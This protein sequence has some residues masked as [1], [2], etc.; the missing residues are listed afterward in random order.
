MIYLCMIYLVYVDDISVHD[1]SDMFN[2]WKCVVCSE[3]R[4]THAHGMMLP[5]C[6]VFPLALPEEGSFFFR[7]ATLASREERFN[8]NHSR[9]W[10]FSTWVYREFGSSLWPPVIYSSH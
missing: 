2:P 8:S 4:Y 6:T 3:K 1:L 5:T 10:C 7:V 9:I